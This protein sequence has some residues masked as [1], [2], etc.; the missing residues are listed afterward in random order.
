LGYGSA[1]GGKRVPLYDEYG[2]RRSSY[3]PLGLGVEA[4]EVASPPRWLSPIHTA[5]RASTAL[6]VRWASFR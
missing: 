1:S 5:S 6:N 4:A 2:V 3:V